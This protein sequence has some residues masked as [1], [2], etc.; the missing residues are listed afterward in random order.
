MK[1]ILLSLK[2]LT[3]I[4]ILTIAISTLA[5]HTCQ[6]QTFTNFPNDSIVATG[7]MNVE[8]MY[9]IIQM[10]NSYDTLILHWQKVSASLPSGWT[11][12]ICD[13]NL[14]YNGL[15]QGGIMDTVTTVLNGLLSVHVAPHVNPGIGII[16]Y[17]VWDE[18][19]PSLRDTLTWIINAN[20]IGI[21]SVDQNPTI[22]FISGNNLVVQRNDPQVNRLRLCNLEGRILLESPL[23]DNKMSFDVSQFSTGVYFAEAI[24]TN[25]IFTRKILIR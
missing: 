20:P 11:A 17:E 2:Q 6:S 22:I 18:S 23:A 19:Y 8:A 21:N 10:D 7:T 16:R 24:G 4:S 12:L 1:N 5:T 15:L 9:D 13:N 14:C 25:S 3:V